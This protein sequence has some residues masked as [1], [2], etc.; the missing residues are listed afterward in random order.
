[1]DGSSLYELL[2]DTSSRDTST[3]SSDEISPSIDAC[4]RFLMCF[5]YFSIGIRVSMLF[6][7]HIS[8]NSYIYKLLQYPAYLHSTEPTVDRTVSAIKFK[9]FITIAMAFAQFFAAGLRLTLW[10][11]GQLNT[12]QQSMMVKNIL[13]FSPVGTALMWSM[14][15]SARNWNSTI[16]LETYISS[17]NWNLSI[18]KPSRMKQIEFF[19]YL[20]ILSYCITGAMMSGFLSNVPSDINSKLWLLNFFCDIL[21][22]IIFY[23]TCKRIHNNK[24]WILFPNKL[25]FVLSVLLIVNLFG[26]RVPAM[27]WYIYFIYY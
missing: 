8:P 18:R 12:V 2:T 25:G 15:A 26:A 27:Y 6:C 3:V 17:L 13:F 11:R 9:S 10:I 1:M 16:Y 24:V 23:F 19:R 22:C 4:A 14:S 21:L 7:S 20:F 5:W